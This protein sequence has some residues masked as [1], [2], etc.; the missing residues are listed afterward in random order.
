M[1]PP[2]L[3]FSFSSKPARRNG[4]PR[5]RIAGGAGGNRWETQSSKHSERSQA[6]TSQLASSSVLGQRERS[7]AA[8][9]SFDLDLVSALSAR[10]TRQSNATTPRQS[11][12]TL[13]LGRS[14]SRTGGRIRMDS[15]KSVRMG[16]RTKA[17]PNAPRYRPN[18]RP[19]NWRAIFLTTLTVLI[20]SYGLTYLFTSPTLALRSVEI[21]GVPP[22]TA[23]LLQADMPGDPLGSNVLRYALANHRAI[24][25][26]IGG[27]EADFK[28]VSIGIHLPHTL[29]VTIVKRT[30]VALLSLSGQSWALDERGIPIRL[31]DDPQVSGLSLPRLE[32]EAD[33]GA[34]GATPSL[35]RALP[36]NLDQ[37]VTDG[38]R[39]LK[40]LRGQ[41]GLSTVSAVQIDKLRN[42]T[43]LLPD[44]LSIKLG[45]PIEISSK[46]A[47]ANTLMQQHPDIAQQAAYIDVSYPARPAMLPRS[48]VVQPVRAGSP[49]E[50][51]K[52]I[53][54][55][56][57]AP[58]VVNVVPR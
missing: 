6:R 53:P 14:A 12:E 33:P 54:G 10:A 57:N 36:S 55:I 44:N 51:S 7:R 28:S 41:A 52:A 24:R 2:K 56:N 42:V 16:P 3:P 9:D 17:I 35:G 45:Q 25:K 1:K 49:D 23:Q 11:S 50:N 4:A 46:L 43:L 58:A 47:L 38:Y 8:R 20:V 5:A 30:P 39:L 18:A 37:Q 34:G 26:S 48:A 15:P 19:A 21:D 27:A 31:G 32:V 29:V 13:P 22:A 40:A